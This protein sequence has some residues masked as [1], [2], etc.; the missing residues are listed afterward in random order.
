M[1]THDISNALAVILPVALGLGLAYLSATG[2][3]EMYTA[4]IVI[5]AIAIV[6]P[7]AA[8]SVVEEADGYPGRGE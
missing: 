1:T 8:S 3:I 4:F 2:S 6:I 7:A 5:V